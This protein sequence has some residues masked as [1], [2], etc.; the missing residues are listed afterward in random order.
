MK[1][2][3]S[4]P[5]RLVLDYGPLA[6]FFISYKIWGLMP[7]TGLLMAASVVTIIASYAILKRLAWVPLFT[8]VIVVIFGGLTLILKDETFIKMKPTII[9]GLFSVTLWAG[10]LLKRPLLHHVLGEGL[11][12]DADGWRQLE[13]RLAI[14]FG[15]MAILNEIIWRTMSTDTWINFKVFGLMGLTVLFMLLQ[16]PLI[17]RHQLPENSVTENFPAGD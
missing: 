3:V 2:H 17:R 12:L 4:T 13:F 15:A 14:F 10:L 16:T 1:S 5:T 9:E 7:A 8:A 6:V 11:R